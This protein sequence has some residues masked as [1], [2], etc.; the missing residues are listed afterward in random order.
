MIFR[1][2]LLIASA[3]VS[4]CFTA[5]KITTLDGNTIITGLS[6]YSS[7]HKYDH[8]QLIICKQEAD[9]KDNDNSRNK[10]MDP[11]E[12]ASPFTKFK[13]KR[14]IRRYFDFPPYTYADNLLD[15]PLEPE[16]SFIIRNARA[17]RLVKDRS[18]A[19]RE[20]FEAENITSRPTL[21][22]LSPP[23]VKVYSKL[24]T[25]AFYRLGVLA[26]AYYSFP[27]LTRTLEK[28]VTMTP[29]LL[30]ELASK[31]APGIS[32]LYGT[33]I[34]LTL[35]ILY[36]RLNNIQDLVATESSLIS[37]LSQSMLTIFRNDKERIIRGGQCIADQIR[38]LVKESRGRE[39]MSVIYSDPYLRILELLVEKE[40]EI[41]TEKGSNG[42]AASAQA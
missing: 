3:G 38:I 37:F 5:P 30:E 42:V 1:L 21:V 31:F 2:F 39:L 41:A 12:I 28:T 26:V 10:G 15:L 8:R 25:S 32:I 7:I 4:Y 19:R 17:T 29:D 35:S 6:K 40:E 18:Y 9:E 34:S 36:D 20:S 16:V 22:D 24:W 33:F 13:Q 23:K 27:S 11:D 14:Q